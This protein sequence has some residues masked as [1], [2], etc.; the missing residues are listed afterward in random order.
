MSPKTTAAIG[1]RLI[2]IW[3]LLQSLV[4]LINGLARMHMMEQLVH[5]SGAE[6][7]IIT[8]SPMAWPGVIVPLVI[9]LA[10]L[11]LSKPLAKLVSRKMEN[12]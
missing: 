6:D 2:G 8:N 11:L 5:N 1:L 7:F 12:F 10:L 9:G 4:A 3:F